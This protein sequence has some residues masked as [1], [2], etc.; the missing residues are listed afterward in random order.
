[1]WF[2]RRMLVISFAP[3]NRLDQKALE[4]GSAICTNNGLVGHNRQVQ[5]KR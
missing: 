3:S 5:Y 4:M 1:M 2:L